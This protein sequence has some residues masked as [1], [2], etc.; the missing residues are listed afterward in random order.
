MTYVLIVVYIYDVF[1]ILILQILSPAQLVSWC[2]S[3]GNTRTY[4]LY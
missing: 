4:N 3:I 1:L 2:I